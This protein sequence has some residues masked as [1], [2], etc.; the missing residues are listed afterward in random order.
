MALNIEQYLGAV[1]QNGGL[2]TALPLSATSTLA[3]T[4]AST[5]T[6]DVTCAGN[7]SV[8]G[9][10]TYSGATVGGK[11]T[12]VSGSGATVTLTAAQSGSVCLFDRAAGI[13]FTLPAPAVGLTFDF[14]TTVSI[15]SNAAEVDTSS[16]SVFI[17]GNVINEKTDGTMLACFANGTSTVKI[18]SNGTTTGGLLGGRFNLTCISATVWLISGTVEGSGTIATPFA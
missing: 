1:Q 12:I 11:R 14:V 5:L 16:S 10:T 15:T 7:L 3:V 2:A 6:G 9:T 13:V 17:L 8:T 4:G 18:A